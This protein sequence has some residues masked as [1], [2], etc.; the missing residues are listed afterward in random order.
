MIEKFDIPALYAGAPSGER[1]LDAII[2]TLR[3]TTII[4]AKDMAKHLGE[5]G[6][7]LSGYVEVQTGMSLQEMIDLWRV[8]QAHDLVMQNSTMTNDE[9]SAAL[10]YRDRHS[11]VNNFTRRYGLTPYD[12]RLQ[13]KRKRYQSA[14]TIH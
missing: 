2:G 1:F 3:T 9:I 10:G 5:D 6:R 14:G 4:R 11:L 12:Y 13:R 8:L 7:K